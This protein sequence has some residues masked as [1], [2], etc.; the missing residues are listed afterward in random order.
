MTIDLTTTKEISGV[1][2]ST[3]VCICRL[4][5]A[6][7]LVDEDLDKRE[8]ALLEEL[9]SDFGFTDDDIDEAIGSIVSCSSAERTISECLDHIKD[10][11][12]RELAAAAIFEI[13]S[14]D[15]VIHAKEQLFLDFVKKRWHVALRFVSKPIEWDEE[16]A[17]I[18][19]APREARFFV[20]AGP[21]T[22]KTAV[23]CARVANL[24]ED[25]G[26]APGNIWMISFTRAAVSE[27]NDRIS[28]FAEDPSST[29]GVAIG[30][31]D[32]KAWHLRNG[33]E[34]DTAKKLFGGFD[35]AIDDAIAKID[36]NIEEYRDFFDDI[37]HIILDEAQDIN[38]IR[39]KFILKLLSILNPTCGLTLFHDPAQ[40]IYDYEF[41]EDPANARLTDEL[42]SNGFLNSDSRSLSRIHRTD[43]PALL[44][45]YEDLR[46][47]VLSGT[48]DR[49]EEHKATVREAAH[50][51]LDSGFSPREMS[52]YSNA[53]VLFRTRAQAVMASS[54]MCS[55]GILH[56]IR[57]AQYPR[58]LKPSIAVILTGWPTDQISRD[59]LRERVSSL[60]E[61]DCAVFFESESATIA[62]EELWDPIVRAGR[63]KSSASDTI[64]RSLLIERLRQ[65]P[66]ADLVSREI[67]RGGPIIGTIHSSK[68]HEADEVVLNISPRWG[69]ASK[70]A[71]FDEKEEARVLFVG[72]SRA[73]NRLVIGEGLTAAYSR[74][75]ETSGRIFRPSSKY[76]GA[77]VQ[78]GLAND[79]DAIPMREKYSLLELASIRLPAKCEAHLE[80]P[81]GENWR[82]VLR[83]ADDPHSKNLPIAVMS[84]S[85]SHDVSTIGKLAKDKWR[86]ASPIKN[87]SVIGWRSMVNPDVGASEEIASDDQVWLA[88]IVVGFPMIFF[89]K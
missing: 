34:Y 33:F 19:S 7:S 81:D 55:E 44:A 41:R 74:S 39:A 48:T 18:I 11:D 25:Q 13:A 23:A 27:L 61:G 50:E 49:F 1:D 79:I 20:S 15:E 2:R 80:R 72:A 70:Q 16:Q 21:G 29:L 24:I 60:F 62:F 89:R 47:D 5:V 67:G 66:P 75:L 38:G 68:G 9:A 3:S 64:S 69:G 88:P 87:I 84:G 46:L 78:V 14:A 58:A 53:L 45:L 4:L 28:V 82:W 22:G 30:T 51:Q 76:S 71:S 32:S 37:E 59:A 54:F 85:F 17:R 35:T 8:A 42:S 86:A 77:S 56:R 40:A 12:L 31:I 63:A 65:M 52:S 36:E 57:M 43:D 10:V 73:K 6:F 83:L 26:V